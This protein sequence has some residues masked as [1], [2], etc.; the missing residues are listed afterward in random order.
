MEN[1][2]RNIVIF[3]GAYLLVFWVGFNS[4]SIY[5]RMHKTMKFEQVELA[6]AVTP[7]AVYYVLE[8]KDYGNYKAVTFNEIYEND[9]LIKMLKNEK[10]KPLLKERDMSIYDAEG[11]KI[12]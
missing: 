7:P 11:N 1:K 9:I 8:N 6:K 4:G 10:L 3:I 5:S 12:Y 2:K